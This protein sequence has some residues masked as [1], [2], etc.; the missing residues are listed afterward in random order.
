MLEWDGIEFQ[1]LKLKLHS[2]TVYRVVG[3]G[4]G[5]PHRYPLS[6]AF[7]WK[8]HVL[9]WSFMGIMASPLPYITLRAFQFA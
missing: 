8:K 2:C 1:I 4:I 3:A 5:G 9:S 6:Y 7:Q